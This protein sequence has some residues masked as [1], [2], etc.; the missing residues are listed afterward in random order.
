[1]RSKFIKLISFLLVI[2]LIVISISIMS[3]MG[4]RGVIKQALRVKYGWESKEQLK[5]ISTVGFWNN[6]DEESYFT[7]RTVYIISHIGLVKYQEDEK[8]NI[9]VEVTLY[10]PDIRFV[11]FTLHKTEDGKYLIVDVMNDL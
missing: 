3:S 2:V 5:E 6:L 9:N 11:I 7:D 10:C 1:M 8:D 4:Y